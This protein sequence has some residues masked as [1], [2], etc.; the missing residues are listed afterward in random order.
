MKIGN[1]LVC[2]YSLT[3]TEASIAVNSSM[4]FL[5]LKSIEVLVGSFMI[6]SLKPMDEF[7]TLK[8]I[9]NIISILFLN[10]F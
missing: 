7:D 4:I 1:K 5:S 2:E 6:V 9:Y 8:K 3:I 10:N